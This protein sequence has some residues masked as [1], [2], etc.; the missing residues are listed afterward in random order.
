MVIAEAELRRRA[1]VYFASLRVPRGARLVL[2]T[3]A[4]AETAVAAMFVADLVGVPPA[5]AGMPTAAGNGPVV[6]DRRNGAITPLGT[7]GQ[8]AV[9]FQR[10]LDA[11]AAGPPPAYA[12]PPPAP[13]PAPTP[14]P[15]PRG[16]PTAGPRP[17]G[18]VPPRPWPPRRSA[19]GRGAT[20]P[21]AT[22]PGVTGPE[23]PESGP[24]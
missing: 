18:P 7:G 4:L 22:G 24:A 3:A 9:L 2:R 14:A 20:G 11:Q 17:R 10:Y 16:R 21:G 5:P 6:I 23:P 13:G 19:D 12:D 8:P 15:H 1:A